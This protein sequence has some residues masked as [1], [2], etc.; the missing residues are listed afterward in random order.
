MKIASPA[1]AILLLAGIAGGPA[2]AQGVPPGSYTK[3]CVNVGVQG[4]SLVANCRRADGHE[5]RSALAGFRRCVGDIGNN[6]GTLE[7]NAAGGPMRGQVMAG[8]GPGP[9][10]G[11]RLG[12]TPV[13]GPPPY[14]APP[15]G[16]AP[17]RWDHCHEMHE[18][19]EAL[20]AQHDREANP[21][22]RA[23]LEGRLHELREQEDR[24]R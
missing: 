13:A 2:H 6:N 7:C 14:G 4:D 21:V 3:S 10:P 11:P 9:G 12:P 8:P 5:D 1:L 20:R 17:A 23:R 22:E 19:T 16:W 24:C 18:R 15:P